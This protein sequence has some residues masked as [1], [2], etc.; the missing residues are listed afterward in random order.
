MA[1][2]SNCLSVRGFSSLRASEVELAVEEALVNI[3]RYAYPN[4]SGDVEVRCQAVSDRQL[5]IE[6]EDEGIPFNLLSIPD[7]EL[8]PDIRQRK[9]G[10]LGIFFIRRMIG[11]IH[12]RREADRN[13]LTMVVSPERPAPL[14]DEPGC[15]HTGQPL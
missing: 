1:F 13:V 8:S 5:I 15:R 3:F 14:M 11:D 9:I 6:I 2:V 10:G 4:R 7:P 12:Y